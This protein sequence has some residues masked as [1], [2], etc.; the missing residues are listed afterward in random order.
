MIA[1][2]RESVA[3]GWLLR[4]VDQG[5]GNA[6]CLGEMLAAIALALGHRQLDALIDRLEQGGFVTS[7]WMTMCSIDARRVDLTRD[8]R[9]VVER[10][11]RCDWIILPD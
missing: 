5:T 8:G 7:A 3:A 4:L 2:V 9:D 11:I 6:H 1:E 10:R